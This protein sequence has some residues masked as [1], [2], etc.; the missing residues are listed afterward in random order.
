VKHDRDK[1]GVD[2]HVVDDIHSVVVD[3]AAFAEDKDV[4]DDVNKDVV[5]FFLHHADV[6]LNSF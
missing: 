4:M 6:Y 3:T 1:Q 5:H 2:V